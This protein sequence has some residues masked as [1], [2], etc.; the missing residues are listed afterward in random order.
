MRDKASY[1]EASHLKML[2]NSNTSL[3]K[4]K[5]LKTNENNFTYYSKSSRDELGNKLSYY[6]IVIFILQCKVICRVHV[7]NKNATLYEY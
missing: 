3:N 2:K 5:C 7:D 1:K 6:G 4:S